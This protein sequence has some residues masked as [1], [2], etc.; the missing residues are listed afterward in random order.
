[1]S[2]EFGSGGGGSSYT[3]NLTPGS[4]TTYDGF[5]VSG[6]GGVRV[7]PNSS[8]PYY[9]NYSLG[10]TYAANAGNGAVIISYSV[11]R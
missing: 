3:D 6:S 7:A 11:P 5:G 9:N 2:G 4:I 1:M 8:S 10:G